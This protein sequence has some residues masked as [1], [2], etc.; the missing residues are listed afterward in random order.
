MVDK[1]IK[2]LVVIII[3]IVLIVLGIKKSEKKS[4]GPAE[5]NPLYRELFSL[6]MSFDNG[7]L[8]QHHEAYADIIGKAKESEINHAIAVTRG[9]LETSVIDSFFFSIIPS[10][11]SVIA[12]M[13][14]ISIVTEL[15]LESFWIEGTE[16]FF[17]ALMFM[18]LFFMVGSQYN[19]SIKRQRFFISLLEV[20]QEKRIAYFDEKNKNADNIEKSDR[21]EGYKSIT[22][23]VY[24]EKC[25]F[26]RDKK[27]RKGRKNDKKD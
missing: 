9:S 4:T 13:Y 18:I 11:L 24:I 7:F 16:Q 22:C 8:F 19:K 17:T 14:A 21:V 23:D 12:K 10:V 3:I 5:E 27:K 26:I 1:V 25:E 2:F 20:E 6:F 15:E